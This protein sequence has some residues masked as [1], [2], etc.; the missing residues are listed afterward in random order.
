MYTQGLA[1]VYPIFFHLLYNI[2]VRMFMTNDVMD[3]LHTVTVTLFLGVEVS[4]KKKKSRN[5]IA[6]QL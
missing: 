6:T 1:G 2:R 5:Q 4:K 3:S